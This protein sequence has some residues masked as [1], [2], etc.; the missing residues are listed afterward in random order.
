MTRRATPASTARYL[1]ALEYPA[2]EVEAAIRQQ[3]P[4]ADASA[5]VTFAIAAREGM[6]GAEQA[7]IREE[8]R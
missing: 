3:F 6:E 7:A 1:C 2:A 4:E 5:V 8:G